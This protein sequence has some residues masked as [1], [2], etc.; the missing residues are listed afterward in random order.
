MTKKQYEKN[1]KNWR[2]KK[3]ALYLLGA[4]IIILGIIVFIQSFLSGDPRKY[5]WTCVVGFAIASV[6]FLIFVDAYNDTFNDYLSKKMI[7]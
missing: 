3:V 2:I 1:L 4:V 7:R 6:G 5:A